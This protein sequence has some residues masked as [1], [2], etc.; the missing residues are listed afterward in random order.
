MCVWEEASIR[1]PA[2]RGQRPLDPAEL[3]R[4][5]LLRGNQ[6][7][8]DGVSDLPVQVS[9]I[10]PPVL[11]LVSSS[12]G[13]ITGDGVMEPLKWFL[14]PPSPLVLSAFA[15]VR[16]KQEDSAWS[17]DKTDGDH[18]SDPSPPRLKALSVRFPPAVPVIVQQQRSCLCCGVKRFTPTLLFPGAQSIKDK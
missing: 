10:G 8:A 1:F 18:R 15:G 6:T 16:V 17:K 5:S 4:F 2:S 7:A 3:F 13:R 12:C 9:A 14:R 11:G